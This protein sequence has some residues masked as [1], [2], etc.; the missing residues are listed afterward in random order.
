M[1][2]NHRLIDLFPQNLSNRLFPIS[3]MQDW[4]PRVTL[5]E[6]IQL[7]PEAYV[8]YIPPG[9]ARVFFVSVAVKDTHL[10]R[11]ITSARSHATVLPDRLISFEKVGARLLKDP[12]NARR[13]S[14][15][16]TIYRCDHN[17]FIVSKWFTFGLFHV[18]VGEQHVYTANAP[19]LLFHMPSSA[20]LPGKTPPNLQRR[21]FWPRD[22]PYFTE[23]VMRPN[24]TYSVPPGTCYLIITLKKYYFTVDKVQSADMNMGR[25]DVCEKKRHLEND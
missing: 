1:A 25:R 16:K 11:L 23:Y 5:H 21:A 2:V 15:V 14:S 13:K 8:T 7:N 22:F 12:N 20:P 9:D 17:I 19:I 24:T 3:R 10:T 18:E 4:D 6:W